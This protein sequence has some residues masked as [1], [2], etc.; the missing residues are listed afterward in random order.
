MQQMGLSA[1]L[2]PVIGISRPQGRGALWS[3]PGHCHGD[4]AMERPRGHPGE[5]RPAGLRE[6][7]EA[8]GQAEVLRADRARAL[9]H[10]W[11]C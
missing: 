5:R 10:A 9:G 1:D 7:L 8:L 6:G 11:A 4:V 2:N 3:C